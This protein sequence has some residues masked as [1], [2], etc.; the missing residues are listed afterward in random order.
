[1][2][3]HEEL[4]QQGVIPVLRV[5]NQSIADAVLD[6]L[7]L[8]GMRA[9]EITLTSAGAEALI[10]RAAARA[11]LLV[12]AGTVL[13]SSQARTC[14]RAGAKFIVSPA[15]DEGVMRACRESRVPYYPGAVTPTEIL[16]AMRAGAT[17]VKVFPISNFGG[18]SYLRAIRGPFPGFEW[19][20]TG[21]IE[22]SNVAEYVAAGASILGASTALLRPELLKRERMSELTELARA[23]LAEFRKASSK[24]ERETRVQAQGLAE[25][26][27]NLA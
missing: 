6:A 9:I 7:A 22:L 13:D 26:G 4:K 24:L 21:G 16:S 20:V 3:I 5:A 15:F 12:G 10:A 2:K 25:T 1:M 27:S 8:G 18:P 11:D 14:I 19:M 23:Y 17:A